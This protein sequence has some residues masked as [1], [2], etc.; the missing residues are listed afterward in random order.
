MHRYDG[1][2]VEVSACGV[3][4][5]DLLIHHPDT[6]ELYQPEDGD[7]PEVRPHAGRGRGRGQG[8]G[9]GRGRRGGGRGR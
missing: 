7:L 2:F 5:D 3:V 9:R 8:R 4:P 6:L 1:R